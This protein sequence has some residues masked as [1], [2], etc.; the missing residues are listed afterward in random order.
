M[1][2]GKGCVF[3]VSSRVLMSVGATALFSIQVAFLEA[4]WYCEAS[5]ES[6]NIFLIM[7][8]RQRRRK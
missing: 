7:G 6:G 8:D 1:E 4:E 5:L 3:M 2:M